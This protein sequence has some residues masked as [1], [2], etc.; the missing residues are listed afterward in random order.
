M[1]YLHLFINHRRVV[2]MY[3][4]VCMY[5]VGWWTIYFTFVYYAARRRRRDTYPH[6]CKSKYNL[7]Y[8]TIFVYVCV[9]NRRWQH[10][11]THT[12]CATIFISEYFCDERVS[13]CFSR[14]SWSI[15]RKWYRRPRASYAYIFTKYARAFYWF[16]PRQ[17]NNF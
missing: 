12:C 10:T 6:I 17:A 7:T 8:N 15:L 16:L 2:Y 9:Y 1:C 14:I 11:H 4:Y 5:K 13:L 3:V